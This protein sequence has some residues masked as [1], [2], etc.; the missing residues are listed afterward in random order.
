MLINLIKIIHTLIVLS[1]C[2]SPFIDNI[3]LKKFVF[4]FLLYLLF[5][6]ISGY[7]RC[8]LT[9]LEYLVMGEE[10]QQGFMYRIINP[11]IKVPEKYFDKYIFVIHIIYIF[12]LY[13]QLKNLN[14]DF[15][16]LI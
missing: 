16:M 9:E 8:G 14:F 12:I 6:Y 2:V 3:I 5:Q 15:K 4:V 13:S 10:Y 1:V 11:L 7:E